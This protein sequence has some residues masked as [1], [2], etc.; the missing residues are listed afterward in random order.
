MLKAE[1]IGNLP[2]EVEVKTTNNGKEYFQISVAHDLGKDR[3]TVWVNVTDYRSV[4]APVAKFLKKGAKV[5]VSGDLN[6][7]NW[8]NRNGEVQT[9]I[10]IF[11]DAITMVL[12]ARSEDTAPQQ[13][14]QQQTM[15]DANG[16]FVEDLPEF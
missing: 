6:V 15:F 13:A 2:R 1:V 10:E 14:P 7:R 12:F 8:T 5:R 16:N 11:P 4:L 3:P 9:T